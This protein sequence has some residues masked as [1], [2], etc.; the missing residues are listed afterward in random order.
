MIIY[1][2]IYVIP[3]PVSLGL[4]NLRWENHIGSY[5][6]FQYLAVDGSVMFEFVEL[7]F[8]ITKTEW[9]PFECDLP[10]MSIHNWNSF[11]Y[12]SSIEIVHH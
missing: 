8:L 3:F 7:F 12:T 4:V 1:L 9:I 2:W 5:W 6:L 10:E 11:K